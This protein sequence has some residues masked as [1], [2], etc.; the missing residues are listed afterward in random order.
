M[1]E[2]Q[3]LYLCYALRR[4]SLVDSLPKEIN[5]DINVTTSN[6]IL[7]FLCALLKT[8]L[9]APMG[10]FMS[11]KLFF[12]YDFVILPCAAVSFWRLCDFIPYFDF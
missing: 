2:K 4:V 12:G 9:M 10:S 8:N 11:V 6:G 7:A 5:T 1:Q 3:Y